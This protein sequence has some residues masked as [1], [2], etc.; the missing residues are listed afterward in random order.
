MFLILVGYRGSVVL[1]FGASTV[2]SQVVD[3]LDAATYLNNNNG[4]RPSDVSL[5]S[6]TDTNVPRKRIHREPS[7]REF[8]NKYF[9]K[10]ILQG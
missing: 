4:K 8:C 5:K 10:L 7:A 9:L 3:N 6:T 2:S 1:Y